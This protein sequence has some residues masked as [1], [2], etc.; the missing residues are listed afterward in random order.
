METFCN[1]SPG[2]RPFSPWTSCLVAT[3][4]APV[5]LLT[6]MMNDGNYS[7]LACQGASMHNNTVR[8]VHHHLNT[9]A[10]YRL[11]DALCTWEHGTHYG[12]V[13]SVRHPPLAHVFEDFSCCWCPQ[14]VFGVKANV[15]IN[16]RCE[17]TKSSSKDKPCGKTKQNKIQLQY[18]NNNHRQWNEQCEYSL[19]DLIWTERYMGWLI[20][21]Q[22]DMCLEWA[23][24]VTFL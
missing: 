8:R 22:P 18:L 10:T 19:A 5:S 16:A 24:A 21:S 20:N 6:L 4:K 3:V 9:S 15:G 2:N 11:N 23:K 13:L 12:K 7:M 17:N 14:G 1:L